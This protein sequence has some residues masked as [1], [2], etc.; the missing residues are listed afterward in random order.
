VCQ[1]L[2]RLNSIETSAPHQMVAGCVHAILQYRHKGE[3]AAPLVS[4]GPLA[5]LPA[6][7]SIIFANNVQLIS[8]KRTHMMQ[9]ALVLSLRNI[10]FFV[11]TTILSPLIST[12]LTKPGFILALAEIRG[13]LLVIL[14]DRLILEVLQIVNL[15]VS[16]RLLVMMG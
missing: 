3:G 1:Y 12:I 6:T 7:Q 13:S 15:L 5:F 8:T 4:T 2:D 14:P 16:V 10:A 11:R 9:K